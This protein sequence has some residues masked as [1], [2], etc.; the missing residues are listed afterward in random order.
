MKN[1]SS[2]RDARLRTI[3]RFADRLVSPNL[4]LSRIYG[5]TVEEVVKIKSS[6][7]GI[8]G[9]LGKGCKDG[10]TDIDHDHKCPECGFWNESNKRWNTVCQKCG[11]RL[12]VRG[13]LCSLHNRIIGYLEKSTNEEIEKMFEWMGK[14]PCPD[15]GQPIK[16]TEFKDHMDKYH[17]ITISDKVATGDKSESGSPEKTNLENPPRCD[18]PFLDDHAECD[19]ES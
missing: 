3:M 11:A 4:R 2:I 1:Y 17:P 10:R 14:A 9:R 15:C 6:P 8:C 7:C 19:G 18:T 12:R 13:P 5:I 16:A